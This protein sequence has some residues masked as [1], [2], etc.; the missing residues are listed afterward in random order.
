MAKTADGSIATA[1][2]A[3][4]PAAIATSTEE[5]TGG[6]SRRADDDV[7]AGLAIHAPLWEAGSVKSPGRA[8]LAL[9]LLGLAMGAA[10]D[11]TILTSHHMSDRG[12]WAAFNAALG[13]AFTGT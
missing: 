1:M 2:T 10:A 3:P 13:L 6:S 9:A 7:N 5:S 8:L 11:A 12:T 4:D